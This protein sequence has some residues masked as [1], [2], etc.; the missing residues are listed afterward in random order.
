MGIH[1]RIDDVKA[2]LSR[3]DGDQNIAD[4]NVGL[5]LAEA[6]NERYQPDNICHLQQAAIAIGETLSKVI[7]GCLTKAEAMDDDVQALIF[8]ATAAR[9]G[10]KKR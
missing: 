8:A 10:W 2:S 9:M 5:L 7:P 4:E 1:E 3:T 6:F